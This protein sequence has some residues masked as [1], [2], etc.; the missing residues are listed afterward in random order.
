MLRC[1]CSSKFDKKARHIPRT[2]NIGEVSLSVEGIPM[3]PKRVRS[4]IVVLKLPKGPL[5][6]DIG[7]PRVVKQRWSDPWL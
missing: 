7:I 1:Q 4:R 5:V 3:I 6:H 2:S